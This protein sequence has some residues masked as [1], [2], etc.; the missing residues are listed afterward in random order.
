MAPAQILDTPSV[1]ATSAFTS[2]SIKAKASNSEHSS[3]PDES[4]FSNYR[5]LVPLVA[6]DGATYLNASFSPPS[7]LIVHDA[8]TKYAHDALHNPHPKP[9]WQAAAAETRE[10][11]ARYI[12]AE[13][14]DSVALM[15]DTTEGLNSFIRSIKFSPGDNV[16]LLDSEHPNH[17]YGWMALRASGLEVRQVPSIPEAERTGKVTAATAETF[18]PYVD[19]RTRA[20]GL[21]FIMFHSGQWNDVADIC[22]AFRPR[23]IHVL[24]DMTQQVG[25]ANVDVRALG[26]SAAAFGMHK[27]LNCP[28]GLA[29]LYVDPSIVKEMDPTPPIVGYGTVS[30]VRADLLVPA[31]DIIYHPSARRYEHLNVSLVACV[32]ARAWLKF[33]LG[34]MGPEKVEL[35]LYR[36]GDALRDEC[37]SLKVPIVGP[38]SRK[39]HAPH[40]YILDLHDARW[41][42]HFKEHSIYVT[43]YRLGVRVSFGFYNNMEDVKVLTSV[44]K[45]GLDLGFPAGKN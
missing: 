27:G 5:Q 11:I 8:I 33:Y 38:E 39:E 23:G 21:S 15:R 1:K 40:L 26:V 37:A 42:Q 43:P 32:A 20:I 36:L 12:N 35:H 22:A 6:T 10:L 24:V 13:S 31:D 34:V 17:A 3:P 4:I 25:F 44:L 28:A 16:V 9:E 45:A 29:A 30:N 41:M 14:S 2:T 19:E 18:A 7:N